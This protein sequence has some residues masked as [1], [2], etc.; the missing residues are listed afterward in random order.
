MADTPVIA[1]RSNKNKKITEDKKM[2]ARDMGEMLKVLLPY[3]NI[4]TVFTPARIKNPVTDESFI[5]KVTIDLKKMM[6]IKSEEISFYDIMNLYNYFRIVFIPVLWGIKGDNGLSIHLPESDVTFVYANLEKNIT[7]FKYWLLHELAHA[8]APSL[9]GKESERFADRF[10]AI[11]LFPRETA[12]FYYDE[13]IRIKNKG[14]A[15][16]RIK[17]LAGSLLISTFTICNEI[18]NYAAKS[19]LPVLDFD[20]GGAAVNF[21]KQTG[22]VST[23]IF[24]EETPDSEK[25][26]K[27]CTDDFKTDFFNALSEYIRKEKKEA[28]VVQRLMNIPI[29]D[30]KGVHKILA[31][32]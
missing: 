11:F 19:S 23:I 1:Y 15:I 21:N 9:S 13:I 28:G 14:A 29:A 5:E 16:N 17:A 10:A 25:F 30:A 4:D 32:K 24:N 22:L 3:L 7:D 31:G 20:I 8:I 26:I 12:A 27:I 6:D 2:I 18:N